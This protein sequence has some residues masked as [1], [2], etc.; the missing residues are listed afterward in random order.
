MKPEYERVRFF[1][2]ADMGLSR[3]FEKAKGILEKFDESQPCNDINDA[4]EL[5][6]IYQIF[7]SGGIKQ[8]Y[9]QPYSALVRKIKEIVSRFFQQIDDYSF[10]EQYKLV[11]RIY[12]DNFWEL[13]EQFKLYERIS[14]SAIK[15][16]LEENNLALYSIL[17]HKK[18]VLQY[19]STL[20]EYMRQ[21]RNTGEILIRKYLEKKDFTPKSCYIPPSLKTNEF[22]TILNK[23]IESDDAHIGLLQLLAS[24]QS[25][26]AFPLTDELR[27]KAKKQVAR[28][29]KNRTSAGPVIK[30]E[31]SACFADSERTIVMEEVTP[32]KTK[33]IYDSKWIQDN[34]DYPTILNNFIYLFNYTNLFFQCLFPSIKSEL[35]IFESVIG[36]KGVKEYETGSVFW[37][38]DLK[39]SADMNSYIH[40]LSQYGIHIEDVYKWF[41]T[42]YL[43]NEFG[44]TGFVF[45]GPSENQ[46]FLE[47]CRTLPSEMDGIF[48]Q[49]R[50]FTQ[51]NAIDRE[52]LEMSSNPISFATLPSM[53]QKKYVYPNSPAIIREQ[54][55]MF[56]DQTLLGYFPDQ[57]D[58]YANF[59]DALSAREIYISDYPEWEL[60]DVQW[61]KERNVITTSS[62]G[63]LQMNKLRVKILRDLYE[64]EVV[65]AS[66]YND[67]TEIEKLVSTGDLRYESTLFSVPEQHYLNFMLNKAEYSNGFDLRNKYIHSTYPLDERQQEQDYLRLLKIMAVIIIKINEEFCL[68]FPLSK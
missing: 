48:K 13:F 40:I 15:S 25:S 29:W 23:Y 4:I 5:Y 30:M 66:Y 26:K 56:S 10:K 44:V 52:L 63:I 37:A 6:N 57:D 3:N 2:N 42:E 38:K 50:L 35:G 9:T 67:K 16:L 39:S 61:L 45:N 55:L 58:K 32:F 17:K 21:F 28:S 7:T 34:L 11:C 60:G 1:D 46:P 20:A 54:H 12:I 14:S 53:T 31:F 51:H 68:K 41:F 19:D 8:E 27:L 43:K 18:I 36:V 24:S 49:Y 62:S 47:K 59:F 65:C 22:E 33:Y 64:H